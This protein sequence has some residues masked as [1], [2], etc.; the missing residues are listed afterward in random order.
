MRQTSS[1][2]DVEGAELDVIDGLSET[3]ASGS[4]RLVYCEINS[5]DWYEVIS[6]LNKYGDL[7]YVLNQNDQ[8]AF[9]RAQHQEASS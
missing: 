8:Q 6:I 7:V 3:L 4:V 1:K 9:V 5:Q 2:I